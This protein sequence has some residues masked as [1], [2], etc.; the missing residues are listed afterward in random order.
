MTGQWE[1]AI[2]MLLFVALLGW[3]LR[4]VR[5]AIRDAKPRPSTKEPS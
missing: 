3:E 2:L 1:W 5:K 4:S